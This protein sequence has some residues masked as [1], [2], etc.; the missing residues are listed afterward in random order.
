MASS[1]PTRRASCLVQVNL[2]S[3]QAD[4]GEGRLDDRRRR[5]GER[6]HAAV[7]VHVGMDVQDK[8][9]RHS[10]DGGPKGLDDVGPA[11]LG[12]VG[13]ALDPGLAHGTL[14]AW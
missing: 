13:N 1:S 9:A 6:D 4:G 14:E 5:T 11:T 8:D 10:G 2:A 7:V 12:E 3:R